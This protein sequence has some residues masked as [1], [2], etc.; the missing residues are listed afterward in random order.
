MENL[1]PDEI[2]ER[3]DALPPEKKQEIE[4]RASMIKKLIG[5]IG[6]HWDDI[7][8]DFLVHAK[9]RCDQWFN[10]RMEKG[11]TVGGCKFCLLFHDN[12]CLLR[13][14]WKPLFDNETKE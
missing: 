8:T 2:Q 3:V 7:K 9:K 6:F 13:E 12:Q 11:P 5:F 1:T 14:K 4:F 10:I